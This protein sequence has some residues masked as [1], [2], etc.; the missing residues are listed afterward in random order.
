LMDSVTEPIWLTFSRRQ[1]QAFSLGKLA[2]FSKQE[3]LLSFGEHYRQ[4]CG[5]PTGTSHG[6][7]RA[8][9]KHGWDGVHFP[10]GLSLTFSDKAR[11]AK[12]QKTA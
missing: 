3:V 5:D 2:G 11:E 7:I 12:R 8:F 6:N 1:L 9:M 4:V 10:D